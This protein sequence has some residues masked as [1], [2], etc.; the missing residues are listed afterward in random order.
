MRTPLPGLL[1]S[2]LTL[3]VIAPG[4]DAWPGP[5]TGSEVR[6]ASGIALLGPHDYSAL[7]ARW[8]LS[9]KLELAYNGARLLSDQ[10]RAAFG[11]PWPDNTADEVIVRVANA[12][13]EAIARRW[14]AAGA[15]QS[16]DKPGASVVRDIPR[17]EVGVRLLMVERSIEE[18]DRIQHAVGPGL[19]DLPG[20]NR[21][22]ASGPDVEYNRVEFQTD[23][24]NDAMLRAL[25]A[26]FGTDAVAV[27]IDP[28]LPRFFNMESSA[29]PPIANP[30]VDRFVPIVLLAIA[31]GA[32]V[33]LLI[34]F[35]LPARRRHIPV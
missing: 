29:P 15:Q 14:M 12:E 4:T 10:H 31:L 21:I 27:R 2:A 22:Y 8:R 9:E 7:F 24:L 17:P 18:L 26:R 33:L 35:A 32:A 6:H 19:R 11:H 34:E 30:N 3:T 16:F 25:A 28:H 1:A 23:R 13:G 5:R 20:T